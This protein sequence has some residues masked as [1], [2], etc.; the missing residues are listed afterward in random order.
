MNDSFANIKK[1]DS[2]LVLPKHSSI[3]ISLCAAARLISFPVWGAVSVG[4]LV[5][6]LVERLS[7]T[8]LAGG[9]I[10]SESKFLIRSEN[11]ENAIGILSVCKISL[12]F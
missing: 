2:T 5:A 8:H 11:R 6:Q 9:S 12:I 4:A 10:P 1:G 3:C 7:Y